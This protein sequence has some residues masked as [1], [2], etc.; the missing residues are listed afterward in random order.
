MA[1]K[2]GVLT[3]LPRKLR[4]LELDQGY[5]RLDNLVAF[6]VAWYRIQVSLCM[7][8]SL[9]FTVSGVWC[10]VFGADEG[11]HGLD[12]LVAFAVTCLGVQGL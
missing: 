7:V 6:E 2:L 10:M 4:G 1:R 3:N 5:H 8:Q 9:G 11:Y 12:N